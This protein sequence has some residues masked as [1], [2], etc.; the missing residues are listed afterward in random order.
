MNNYHVSVLLQ[1]AIEGLQIKPGGKYIDGTLGGGG[2]TRKILELGGT[3]LAL[4]VDQEAITHFEDLRF[5]I[6]DLR[7]TLVRENFRNIAEVAKENGFENADGIVFDLGVSSHQFDEAERGF[8][9]RQDALLDMRMDQ[10]LEKSALD[11]VNTLSEGELIAVF[12]GF[13]EERFASKIARRIVE[14]REKQPIRTTQEL[15][16]IAIAV[17]PMGNKA[18][19]A[20]RIFQALRIAVN[21]ELGALKDALNQ[22]VDLLVPGG[23]LVVVTFHSLEERIVQEHIKQFKKEGKIHVITKHPIVPTPE[24]ITANPRSRSAE[25][26]IAEKI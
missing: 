19:P 17:Y 12:R 18:H 23:R 22:S 15:A 14:D 1:E 8:S 16:D 3:V 6:Q 24:E 26:Y 7:V 9:F 5:K 21:D 13:G 2:Y 4:D 25:L 11:L 10:R 20:T